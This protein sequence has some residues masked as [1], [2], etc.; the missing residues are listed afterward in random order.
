VKKDA[1]HFGARADDRARYVKD[2]RESAE[3]FGFPWAFWCLFDSM[4]L[5]DERTRTLD[6]AMFD[7]LGLKRG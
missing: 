7:A 4:G 3:A 6:P 5:I 2:V 1:S